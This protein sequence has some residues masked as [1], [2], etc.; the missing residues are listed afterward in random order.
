MLNI[1]L[2]SVNICRS[3]WF[4]KEADFKSEKGI[5]QAE[6]AAKNEQ[7]KEENS[8]DLK[9]AWRKGDKLAVLTKVIERRGIER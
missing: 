5:R 2:H 1:L 6:L 8:Q 9:K 4:N 7:E 3:G